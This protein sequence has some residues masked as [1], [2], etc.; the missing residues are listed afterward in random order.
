MRPKKTPIS[1]ELRKWSRKSKQESN[2]KINK[3]PR[4]FYPRGFV[5]C[6]LAI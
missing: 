5:F 3:K 4:G 2:S 6:L 1:S